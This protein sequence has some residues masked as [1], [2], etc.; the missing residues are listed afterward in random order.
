MEIKRS[1]TEKLVAWKDS[2]DRRPLIIQGARQIG[3]TWVIKKFGK[4]NFTYLAYFNF[5][6]NTDL[7][8]EF[9]KTKDI[10]RLVKNLAL[11][12]DVPILPEE[13]LIVF[14]EIQEC[15]QA[16]NSL[17]YFCE[18]APEYPVIAAGSLLGVAVHGGMGF[19]VGK[20]D[21]IDMYPVSF[22]EYYGSYAERYSEIVDSC[23][24]LQDF[25]ELPPIVVSSLE[26]A[27]RHYTV[28]GG[29]PRVAVASLDGK[30]NAEIIKE[31][32]VLLL[33]F[34]R[35]FSK[36]AP[37]I[38]FPRI[39]HIWESLPSQLA[40]ENRKF[41]YRVV[42]PGARAREYESALNW[43]KGAG[44]IYQIYCSSKPGLPLSAYDELTIFKI[45]MLDCG[46][47]RALA[48][49]PPELFAEDNRLFMEFKGA[50]MENMVLEQFL[51]ASLPM[52]R[53]WVSDGSAE[54][55]FILQR[56]LEI[57]PVEVKSG[58]NLS[59]KSL[60]VFIKKFQPSTAVILSHRPLEVI[61]G[62]T[63]IIRLPLYLSAW[64]D[65]LLKYEN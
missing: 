52:P 30:G 11:Y 17:K 37:S 60:G 53:Y 10:K 51:A 65:T 64:A 38:E 41:I 43:L 19:P 48:K 9:E 8:K 1:I 15:S 31:Q 20:V 55:D 45:Y 59:G 28:C 63:Q 57:I 29:M 12:C 27:F 34:Y 25:S 32:E 6:V 47:L 18:E 46:L 40:R 58:Q 36:H 22:K 3:K 13:T 56:G 14:D 54:V 61:E 49:M 35:D 21:F 23:R 50:L 5:D 4:S 2:P 7:R 62:P 33:S 39:T 44:L 42:K 16:L 26:D 24:D